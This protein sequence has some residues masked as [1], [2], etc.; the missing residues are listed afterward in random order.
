MRFAIALLALLLSPLTAVAAMPAVGDK[1][2][3][4]TLSDQNGK[5]VHLAAYRGK[6][7]VVVAFYPM[8][9]TPG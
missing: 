5:A 3:D 1:A 6:S 8:A 2:P 7:T 9:F 4:F